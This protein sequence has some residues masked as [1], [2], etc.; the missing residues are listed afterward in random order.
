M[1]QGHPHVEDEQRGNTPVSHLEPAHPQPAEAMIQEA[2][3]REH[4]V[5]AEFLNRLLQTNGSMAR[6]VIEVF[7]NA[8]DL[9][10]KIDA[11][12]V[13]HALKS[14]FDRESAFAS[15][16]ESTFSEG[17]DDVTAQAEKLTALYFLSTPPNQNSQKYASVV[18]T[19]HEFIKLMKQAQD[20][21]HIPKTLS[22]KDAFKVIGQ[23]ITAL[24][25]QDKGCEVT[26]IIELD[27]YHVTEHDIRG[28]MQLADTLSD[29]GCSLSAMEK[30]LLHQGMVYHCVG[31]MVPPVLEAIAEKGMNGKQLGI[32]MLAAH[33]I[34][35]QYEDPGSAWKSVFSEKAFDLLHRAVLFQDKGG[36]G[37]PDMALQVTPKPDEN[38]RSHNLE[39]I[40]RIAHRAP[41]GAD[42]IAPLS[43]AK[44]IKG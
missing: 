33:Y 10:D 44:M 12:L 31:Y 9:I 14:G 11:L 25:L 16:G 42:Q 6:T 39:A 29:H 15:F 41:E 17:I 19:V 4:S 3:K 30:L 26:T 8:S 37:T 24:A 22:A 23:N 38:V 43:V 13:R 32:P 36:H 35:S 5:E 20:E 18:T 34:R 1:T 21:G 27:A 2:E 7:E 28:C 40:V